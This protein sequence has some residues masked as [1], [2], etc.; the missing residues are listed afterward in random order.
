MLLEKG[1]LKICCTFTGKQPCPSVVS[2]KLLCNFIEITLPQ[3]C[4]PVNLLHIFRTS[5]TK[6]TS[7]WLLLLTKGFQNW[8][9]TTKNNHGTKPFPG[10]TQRSKMNSF[11]K[12]INDFWPLTIIAKLSILDVQWAGARNASV[13]GLFFVIRKFMM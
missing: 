11:A 10:F 8:F 13:P 6:N 1:V 7:G 2:V 5:S 4:S 12:T 3:R 9:R